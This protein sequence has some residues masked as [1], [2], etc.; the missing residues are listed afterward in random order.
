VLIVHAKE[1]VEQVMAKPLGT[2]GM[3]PSGSS[4]PSGTTRPYLCAGRCPGKSPLLNPRE[5]YL[6]WGS[7]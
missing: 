3:L 1:T 5:T 7:G 2:H 4:L 6:L